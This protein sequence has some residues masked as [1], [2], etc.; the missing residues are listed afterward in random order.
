MTN[1]KKEKNISISWNNERKREEGRSLTEIEE[2][3]KT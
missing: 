2:K 1:L 3:M